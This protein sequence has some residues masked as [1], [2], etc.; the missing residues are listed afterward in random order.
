M[1]WAIVY[2]VGL[3]LGFG[4]LDLEA[5]DLAAVGKTEANTTA[6]ARQRGTLYRVSHQGNTAWLFGTIHIGKP[7]FY[8]LEPQVMQAFAGAGKFVPEVDMRDTATLLAAL[9]KHAMYGENDALGK[10][11]SADTLRKLKQALAVHGLPFEMVAR[12]KPWMAANTLVVLA[13]KSDGYQ[14]DKGVDMHLLT[15]AAAQGKA[16]QGLESADYQF[17]LLDQLTPAQQEQYLR[18]ALIELKNGEARKKATEL[19]SAWGTAD[20]RK[21]DALLR[22]LMAEKSMTADFTRRILIEKR[23]VEMTEGIARLLKSDGNIFVGIGLLHLIGSGGV[24][25]LLQ[26]RGYTVEKLY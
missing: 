8:P 6:G 16:V 23:N 11:V 12:M 14:A 21:F 9:Q 20:A 4:A 2:L 1:R 22:E 13:L 26:Q 19:L 18:E 24:P 25:A 10:H 7:D 3:F 15:A 17:S 5:R